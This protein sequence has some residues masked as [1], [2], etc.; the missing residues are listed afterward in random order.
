MRT[1]E[2]MMEVLDKQLNLRKEEY[3]RKFG[4]EECQKRD[5]AF[6]QGVINALVWCKVFV[7]EVKEARE[8]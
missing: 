2:E 3:F 1:R 7:L 6:L 8:K 5:E 4:R